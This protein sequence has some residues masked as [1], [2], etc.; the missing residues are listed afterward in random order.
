VVDPLTPAS[1]DTIGI[2]F[3]PGPDVAGRS[4]TLGQ[5]TFDVLP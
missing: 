2:E 1:A 4:A 3:R 5:F